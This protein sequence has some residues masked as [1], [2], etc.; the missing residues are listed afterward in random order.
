MARPAARP[1][2]SEGADQGTGFRTVRQHPD[3]EGNPVKQTL[4]AALTAIVPFTAIVAAGIMLRFSQ[5]LH[6][7]R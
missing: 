5:I 1:T 2:P 3:T 4:Q 7:L 6:M